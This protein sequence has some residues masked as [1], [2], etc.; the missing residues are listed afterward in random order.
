[1]IKA[2]I[3]D[4]DGV[5][6]D[7]YKATTIYLKQLG[8]QLKLKVPSNASFHKNFYYQP[9]HE[10]L[11]IVNKIQNVDELES[12][13][14]KIRGKI[15]DH[16]PY[17]K[18]YEGSDR[19]LRELHKK[20]RLGLASSRTKPGLDWYLK[21]AGTKKYFKVIVGLHHVKHHKPHP[22]PLLLAAKKLIVKPNE[23]VYV[24]DAPTDLQAAR[25]AG[26][27][28]II[29]GRKKVTGADAYITSF[30]RLVPTIGKLENPN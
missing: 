17:H 16:L 5:L 21:F 24:G 25:A 28:I 22:E 11:R 3:F 1:M 23:C 12:R 13:L 26:M 7:S 18:L 14:K 8:T 20:Y 4:I 27:K 30:N 29:Y 19:A 15:T 6:L 10:T 9:I 2:V